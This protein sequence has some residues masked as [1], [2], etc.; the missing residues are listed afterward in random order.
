MNEIDKLIQKYLKGK[1]TRKDK[2]ILLD[3]SFK[4]INQ[5]L[6]NF[7]SLKIGENK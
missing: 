3:F 5:I 2:D 4:S 1:A 6:K 7:K